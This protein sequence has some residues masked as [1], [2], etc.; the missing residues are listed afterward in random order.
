MGLVVRRTWACGLPFPLS[1]MAISAHM[2]FETKLSCTYSLITVSCTSLENS[3]GSATSTSLASCA[4][5]FFSTFVTDSQSTCLS[6]YSF[7]A[8][9]GS[10]ISRCMTPSFRVKS[11]AVP[12]SLSQ[13]FSPARYAAA[14]MTDFPLLRPIILTEQ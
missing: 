11:W 8:C 14:A 3:I 6:R 10:R 2:P 12:V 1:W 13:S 5:D 9:S 4:L 7:G